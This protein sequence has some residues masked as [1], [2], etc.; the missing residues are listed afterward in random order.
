[1]E[2]TIMINDYLELRIAA[3]RQRDALKQA[4]RDRRVKEALAAQR[5]KHGDQQASAFGSFRFLWQRM[6]LRL[7]VARQRS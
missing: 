5:S 1:M 6:R 4:E 2:N 3:D 7:A